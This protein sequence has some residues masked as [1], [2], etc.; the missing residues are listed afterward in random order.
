MEEKQHSTTQA[1]AKNS[2]NSQQKQFQCEKEATSSEEGK[3]QGT[4]HKSIQPGLQN[5]KDSARCNGKFVSDG[6]NHDGITEKGESQSKI[7]EMIS[8]ILNGIPNLY[9]AINEVKIHNSDNNS[10]FCKSLKTNNLNLSQI[11]DHMAFIRG[12]E[13]IKDDFEFPDR[14]VTARFNTLF[15]KSA[16]RWYIKLRQAHGHQSWTWWRT[17]IIDK[18][19]NDAWRLKV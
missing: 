14:L 13:M 6:Q 9:I 7:S 8:D 12:I 16:H 18:W 4:S 11:N 5:P 10:S 15:T 3:R 17:Q 1:S 19:V 2:P